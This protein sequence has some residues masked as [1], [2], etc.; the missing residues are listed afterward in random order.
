M[1]HGS[2]QVG[3][4]R[5]V[6]DYAT[7]AYLCDVFIDEEF[8]GKGLSKWMME[9]I[10]TNPDLSQLRRFT[11]ATKDAHGLYVKFGFQPLSVE[12]NRRFM[13][14]LKDGV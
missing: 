7:F 5:L 3:F 13:S 6:T 4:A 9:C 2:R 10:M 11:L 1:Y 14:I 12:E 8:R